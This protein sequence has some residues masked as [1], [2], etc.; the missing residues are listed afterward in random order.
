[1]A[2]RAILRKPA[3]NPGR[4]EPVYYIHLTKPLFARDPQTGKVGPMDYYPQL[5]PTGATGLTLQE[6][7]EVK[8]LFPGEVKTHRPVGRR[9]LRVLNPSGRPL[10]R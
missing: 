10:G 6:A 4:T 2:D 1:M 8:Q 7:L 5:T 3:A 9:A